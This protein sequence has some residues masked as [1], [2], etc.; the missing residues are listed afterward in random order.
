MLLI[1]EFQRLKAREAEIL[2]QEWDL[3]RVLSKVNYR[4]HTDAIKNYLLPHIEN[5]QEPY[6]YATEAELLNVALFGISAKQWRERNPQLHQKGFNL[7]DIADLHQLTVL[8]NLESYN[9]IMIQNQLPPEQR[10]QE[11]RK[12]AI[13]QLKTLEAMKNYTLDKLKS[14]NQKRLEEEK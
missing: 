10:L 8:S 12:M 2:N 13:E 14:P 3:K 1:K 4:I 7:R 11:L 6:I 9:A 5:R